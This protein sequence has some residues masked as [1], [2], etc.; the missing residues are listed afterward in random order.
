MID[1]LIFV[2]N[3][4]FQI[5][6]LL[7]LVR[8]F[9]SFIPSINWYKQPFE[10]IKDSTDL[11]LNLFRRIIPPFGGLD[12]SPIVAVIVLQLLNYLIIYILFLFK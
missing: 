6:F 4:F 2:T 3:S 5:Y 12:F 7:I 1:N 8:C 9:L 10:A 11:Y